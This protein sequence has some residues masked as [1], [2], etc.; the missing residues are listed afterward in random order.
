[1]AFAEVLRERL[2]QAASDDPKDR[3]SKLD[4]VVD[5]LIDQAR[6]GEV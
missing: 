2:A 6:S 5:A 4:L 1:L 3:R